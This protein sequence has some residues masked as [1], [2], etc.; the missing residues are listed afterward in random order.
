[1]ELPMDLRTALDQELQTFSTK[2]LAESVADLSHQ[3]RKGLPIDGQRIVRSPKDAAAYAAFRLPATY[4]AV[5]SVL[6]QVQAQFPHWRPQSLLDVGAGPGTVMWA[7]THPDL[8][9]ESL[10]KIT[11]LEREANM[12]A[13]GHRLAAHASLAPIREAKWHAIDITQ[14]WGTFPHD[15]VVTSYV[16]GE[17][18]RNN[19]A[20]FIDQLWEMTIHN[21]VIIEPGTPVGF[22]H[23]RE[24]REQLTTMGGK[25]VAP[26]PHDGLCPMEDD[27]WCHFRHR[28]M[29]SRLHRQ[30]KTG[31]LGYEDEKFSY[32]AMSREQGL[33]TQSRVVRHP[34]IRKGH[35]RLQLCTREGLVGTVISRKD[36]ELFRQARNLEWGSSFHQ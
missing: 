24:A 22:G 6:R 10:K 29:R 3:Y 33:G 25:V 2:G 21:L 26:C 15:L 7:A 28:V 23:I 34:Q 18:S 20:A 12:I 16:I 13:M 1:M 11:L 31:E 36:R 27:D 5:Y 30:L 4:G 19:R 9:S 8:W 35:I 32:I 17:L 14:R